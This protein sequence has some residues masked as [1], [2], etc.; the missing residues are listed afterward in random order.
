MP[1][2][3]NDVPVSFCTVTVIGRVM[4]GS[5]IMQFGKLSG[6]SDR[7]KTVEESGSLGPPAYTTGPSC[8]QA[9][10]AGRKR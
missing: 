1:P 8:T 6:V 10:T 7:L 3:V 4:P 9:R 5:A 2:A